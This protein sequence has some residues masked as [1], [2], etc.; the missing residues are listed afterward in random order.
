MKKR[1]LRSY[2]GF[3]GA[4]TIVN[5]TKDVSTFVVSHLSL[6]RCA[7]KGELQFHIIEKSVKTTAW[8]VLSVCVTP[9][10]NVIFIER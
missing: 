5:T 2:S 10:A 9:S 7:R 1:E 3:F 8:Q 4:L 6:T